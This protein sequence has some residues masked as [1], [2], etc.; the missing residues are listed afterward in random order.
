MIPLN[1]AHRISILLSA[2]VL[3]AAA[4]LWRV[5]EVRAEDRSTPLA[6]PQ[7]APSVQDSEPR[8]DLD[9]K[10]FLHRNAPVVAFPSPQSPV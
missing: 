9:T 8:I 4:V 10:I 3:L 1:F 7:A 2:A 5:G 6:P